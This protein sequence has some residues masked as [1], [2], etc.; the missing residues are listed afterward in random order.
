MPRAVAVYTGSAASRV[1]EPQRPSYGISKSGI[2]AL[3]RHVAAG[4][5]R[6]GI[7]ANCVEPGI[8][9]IQAQRV[10]PCTPDISR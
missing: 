5:G 7:R 8:V 6:Q 1:A 2:G 9:L 10:H 3:M 4:W